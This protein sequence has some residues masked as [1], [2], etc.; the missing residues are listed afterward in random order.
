MVQISSSPNRARTASSGTVSPTTSA[1]RKSAS[2]I[3]DPIRS[4][5]KLGEKARHLTPIELR[6]VHPFFDKTPYAASELRIVF[7][8]PDRIS[9]CLVLETGDLLDQRPSR[10]F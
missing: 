4:L 3:R 1:S 7:Y 2:R 10:P 5:H 8:D 9:P 6:E